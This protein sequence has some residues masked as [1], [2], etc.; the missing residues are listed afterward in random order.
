MWNN[1]LY[2]LAVPPSGFPEEID[3]PQPFLAQIDTQLC[4]W[5]IRILLIAAFVVCLLYAQYACSVN[6]DSVQENLQDTPNE[7]GEGEK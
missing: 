6:E 5:I 7:Q 4:I 3:V 2:V 1:F